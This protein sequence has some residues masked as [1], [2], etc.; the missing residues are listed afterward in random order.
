MKRSLVAVSILLVGGLMGVLGS[1]PVANAAAQFFTDPVGDTGDPYFDI[2]TFWHDSD[3]ET[4]ELV[5]G[6][7][8][9]QAPSNPEWDDMYHE[10][11][12]LFDADDDAQGVFEVSV[13]P[14]FDGGSVTGVV[15]RGGTQVGEVTFTRPDDRSLQFRLPVEL[16]GTPGGTAG[17]DWM[18]RGSRG[19]AKPTNCQTQ[20]SSPSPGQ[21][22]SPSPMPACPDHEDR[23][24]QDL[25][26]TVHHQVN[27]LFLPKNVPTTI[28]GRFIDRGLRGRIISEPPCVEGRKV[29][30]KAS[31]RVIA[32]IR[33][34]QDGRWSEI[35]LDTRR[36]PKRLVL[37]VKASSE[38]GSMGT[39]NCLP[40]R[41]RIHR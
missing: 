6:V 7:S 12:F 8:L 23:Y 37:I 29:V 33:T 17:Y 13:T 14:R 21:S 26:D 31:G 36:L 30:V 11:E 4:Y 35:A 39:I 40:D 2:V 19:W 20:S 10:F 34:D 38:I 41:T 1:R 15:E 9:A 32:R 3:L 27:M 24:D 22:P 25:T 28:K 5:H 16:L 18:V